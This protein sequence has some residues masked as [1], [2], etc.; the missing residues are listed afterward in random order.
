MIEREGLEELSSVLHSHSQW[1]TP[2]PNHGLLQPSFGPVSVPDTIRHTDGIALCY[3]ALADV[4]NFRKWA[5]RALDTRSS[6]SG[7]RSA[8]ADSWGAFEWIGGNG[9]GKSRHQNDDQARLGDARCQTENVRKVLG[10]WIANPE[11]FPA[12]GLRG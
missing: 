1:F 9:L 7:F 2:D 10:K 4:S 5:A 6:H 3:G 8:V 12:W 11:T